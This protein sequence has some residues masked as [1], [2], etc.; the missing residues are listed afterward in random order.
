MRTTR[1]HDGNPERHGPPRARFPR[2]SPTSI[3][4]RRHPQDPPAQQPSAPELPVGRGGGKL[5]GLRPPRSAQLLVSLT[6]PLSELRVR[7]RSSGA[8]EQQ[9]LEFCLC[10]LVGVCERRVVPLVQL[11]PQSHAVG[12]LHHAQWAQSGGRDTAHHSDRMQGSE[13]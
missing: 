6:T 7:V 5:C 13:R 1:A 8:S 9:W 10:D 2:P 3:A 12:R 11:M 4:R